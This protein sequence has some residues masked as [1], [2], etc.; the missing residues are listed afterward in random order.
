[1]LIAF[2]A[3]R[4]HLQGQEGLGRY[5]YDLIKSLAKHDN[6]NEYTV[7]LA[8]LVN[9]SLSNYP[10]ITL[11]ILSAP[12]KLAWEQW[13]FP[14]AVRKMRADIVHFTANTGAL[15]KDRAV[16]FTFHDAIHFLPECIVPA[17]KSFTDRFARR[18]RKWLI[19]KLAKQANRIIALS[20][21]T[22]KDVINYLGIDDKKIDVVYTAPDDIFSQINDE[23]YL[24]EILG[25]FSNKRPYVLCL[26]YIYP[27][28]NL[29]GTI[30]A[31]KE[32]QLKAN[33]GH[34][35]I[36]AGMDVEQA[37]AGVRKLVLEDLNKTIFFTGQVTD[38]ELCALYN[39]ADVFL[40]LSLYE[41][42]GLPVI[43]AMSCGTP[44]ICSNRASLPEVAGEASL[45]VDPRDNEQMVQ[46]IVDLLASNSLRKDLSKRGIA[47]SAKFTWQKV[48]KQTLDVY[49]RAQE[50]WIA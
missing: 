43:E 17:A 16:V 15:I 46:A 11:Q 50:D 23:G 49:Q 28:K 30:R 2:D 5:E 33:T 6:R 22:K 26:G 34:I 44:V 13:A 36:I 9:G 40:Y 42:F 35:M 41:G 20:N 3:H 8:E 12:G 4:A 19:P 47:H 31:F 39:G 32:V 18:Y 21:N 7:L 45:L 48:A 37:S 1:M 24:G 38:E 27:R 25:R 29:L 14:R 10:N